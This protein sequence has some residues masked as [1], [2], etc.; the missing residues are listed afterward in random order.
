MFIAFGE[1]S[2][3]GLIITFA[4]GEFSFGQLTIIADAQGFA[5]ITVVAEVAAVT[6]SAH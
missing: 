2:F 5:V 6:A 4:F 1:F 3:G